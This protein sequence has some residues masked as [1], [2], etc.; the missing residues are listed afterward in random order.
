MQRSCLNNK[1]HQF[2]GV[3]T[4]ATHSMLKLFLMTKKAAWG[5]NALVGLSMCL[6][7]GSIIVIFISS[8]KIMSKYLHGEEGYLLFTLPQ[9]GMSIITS[10][11]I[12]AL[13]QI[14]IV[15]FVSILMFNL[16]IPEEIDL[17]ASN[18]G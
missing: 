10:R 12:T 1:N 2:F 11:L 6:L 18:P 15:F 8:L 17:M 7:I 16:I 13:I 9:S 3:G 5:G 14:S 4:T